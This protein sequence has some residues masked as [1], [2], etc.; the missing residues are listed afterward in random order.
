[1]E[2]YLNIGH[3]DFL[4]NVRMLKFGSELRYGIRSPNV[5]TPVDIP[6]F[7]TFTMYM[8]RYWQFYVRPCLKTCRHFHIM[9]TFFSAE[10]K[11]YKSAYG[12][13]ETETTSSSGNDE[14]YYCKICE[15][16][17]NGPIPYNM[18]LKSKAHKEELELRMDD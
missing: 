8:R 16:Q 13:K 7:N 3:T 10:W 4:A 15:K 12:P 6:S 2:N 18:H 11:P 17:L 5:R 9:L 1:M 14:Q